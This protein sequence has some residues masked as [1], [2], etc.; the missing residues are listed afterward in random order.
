[1][2]HPSWYTIFDK[3]TLGKMTLSITIHLKM[4]KP[5]PGAESSDKVTRQSAY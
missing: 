4:T 5:K 2:A 3:M 1:M